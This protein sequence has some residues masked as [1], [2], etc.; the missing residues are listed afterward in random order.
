MKDDY[1]LINRAA[2][3]ATAEEFQH[4]KVIRH[5]GT[6]HVVNDFL[7]VLR[8]VTGKNTSSI[9]ELGPGSGYASMLMAEQ[10][11]KVTAIEF[12]EPMARLAR[13][14]AKSANIVH[15]EFLAHDFGGQKFD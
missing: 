10:G 6:V 9:L 5:D 15:A 12:S 3:D 2:Y 13:D 4:K 7:D 14:T 11:H 8:K 1:I